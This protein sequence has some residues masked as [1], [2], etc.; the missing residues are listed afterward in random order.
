MSLAKRASLAKRIGAGLAALLLVAGIAAAAWWFRPWSE[1]SPSEVYAASRIEDRSGPFRTMHLIYPNR[2]IAA[3]PDHAPLPRAETMIDGDDIELADGRTASLADYAEANNA[4]GFMVLSGGEV[5]LEAYFNGEGA[6]DRHTSWSVAKSVV[7]TLVG[8]ALME[9]RIESLDDP[10]SRYAPDY[11]GTPYGEVSIRH[12]LMMA[13]GIDFEEDYEKDGSDIRKLFFGTFFWNRDVDSIVRQH[14]PDGP[15]GETFDYI[16]SNTAVLAAV[17]RGAYDRP[18]AEIAEEKLLVPIGAGGGTWLTDARDGKEIGYCCLQIT[19][20]DYARLGRLYVDGGEANGERVIPEDW[21]AFVST[22]PTPDHEP[23]EGASGALG[24][25]HHFWLPPGADGE[26]MMA[27]FNGQI[28]WID[29]ER[30]VVVAMT[31]AD[32]GWPAAQPE[33]IAIARALVRRAAALR[34]GAG[35][36]S[37]PA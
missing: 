12:L 24:Y 19:L 27:G 21:V 29:T 14:V 31:G 11:G 26:F 9:G 32:R 2:E 18:L 25:G 36:G 30:D 4:T 17:L 35:E 8:R 7:A 20:E 33:F 37:E 15:A 6:G 5:V 3:A 28:V 1:F 13:S 16:S 22:P 23:G 34:A 10:A